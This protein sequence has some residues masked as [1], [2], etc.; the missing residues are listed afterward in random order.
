M[1]KALLFLLCPVFMLAGCD[2]VYDCSVQGVVL[3]FDDYNDSSVTD[4]GINDVDVYLYLD[5]QIL[6]EDL[7][8]WGKDGTLPDNRVDK[9][10]LKS[11]GYYAKTT[12][13]TT[14]NKKGSF[15]FNGVMWRNLFPEFGKP[16]DRYK[17]YFLFYHKDYGMVKA[18]N[19]VSV[20]S[21]VTNV[22]SQFRIKKALCE[23]ILSGYVV[24]KNKKRKG[25]VNQLPLENVTVN[26]Y[27]PLSFD[28]ATGTASEWERTPKYTVTTDSEGR[29]EQKINFVKRTSPEVQKCPIKLHFEKSDYVA[30]ALTGE[31]ADKFSGLGSVAADGN[32]E[33]NSNN[34][35]L[36][37]GK[38]KVL[39]TYKGYNSGTTDVGDLSEE[40]GGIGSEFTEKYDIDQDGEMEVCLPI[41]LQCNTKNAVSSYKLTQNIF[42]RQYR[43]TTTVGGK[44]LDSTGA[45]YNGTILLADNDAY[46]NATTARTYPTG[47]ADPNVYQYSMEYSWSVYNYTSEYSY[48]LVY[49]K[50]KIANTEFQYNSNG[51]ILLNGALEN[52]VDFEKK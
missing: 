44:I 2:G 1:K 24:D 32:E 23:V 14:S 31:A 46:K 43:F 33:R 5:E 35:V 52:A 10:G 17:F 40:I 37:N 20:T 7:A 50:A 41:I 30:Y 34:W 6:D 15:G 28:S 4:A 8:A 13:E 29:F 9:K 42:L 12:T 38:E 39:L 25:S 21:G 45:T 36:L 47:N 3:D 11:A 18:D 27:M 16:G 51:K 26:I 49:M 48:Q 22:L 19:P